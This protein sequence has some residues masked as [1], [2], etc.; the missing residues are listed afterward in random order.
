MKH[1]RIHDL[2][3]DDRSQTMEKLP[4]AVGD[5]AFDKRGNQLVVVSSDGVYVFVFSVIYRQSEPILKYCRASSPCSFATPL[6]VVTLSGSQNTDQE[7][8]LGILCSTK[9]TIHIFR[10]MS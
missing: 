3:D 7:L 2:M 1:V 10:L 4:W 6:Q 5:L 9:G 8:I